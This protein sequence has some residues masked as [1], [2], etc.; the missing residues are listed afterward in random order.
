MCPPNVNIANT[1]S[2]DIAGA[3]TVGN[4]ATNPVLT[5]EAG[6]APYSA[7]CGG[8]GQIQ[9]RCAIAS[10][11]FTVPDGRRLVVES[12]T[13][14]GDIA[15]GDTLLVRLNGNPA[16]GQDG[17]SSSSGFSMIVPTKLQLGN[18]VFNFYAISEKTNLQVDPNG[19]VTISLVNTC[20]QT[21]SV[22]NLN[23]SGYTLPSP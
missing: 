4:P 14:E 8:G 3:V 20:G 2:V 12:M 9:G 11:T 23:L 17:L 13:G 5:R 15:V 16:S 18:G 6:K 10:C 7:T 21:N 1:P 19:T 22:A